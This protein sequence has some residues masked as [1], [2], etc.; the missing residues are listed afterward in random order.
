MALNAR[1]GPM[2]II[3]A[4]GMA[5]GGRVLHHL[6]HRLGDKRNTIILVGYQA[7]GTR[8]R[9]LLEGAESVKMLGPLCP[10][11]RRDR[12]RAGVFGACRS[13]RIIEW[14]RGARS[15]PRSRLHHPWRSARIRSVARR[16]HAAAKMECGG[17]ASSRTGSD[18][19][20]DVSGQ[21]SMSRYAAR[22][23]HRDSRAD[24]ARRTSR[25]QSARSRR[26]SSRIDASGKRHEI[27]GVLN[28]CRDELV[29]LRRNRP[30]GAGVRGPRAARGRRGQCDARGRSAQRRSGARQA[31]RQRASNAPTSTRSS[32]TS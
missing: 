31:G 9:S 11:A 32:P 19:L 1:G 17:A 22:A 8:G 10:G 20:A 13:Q 30:V 16:D 28:F 26:M 15:P 3:S 7:A 24:R 6:A 21:A 27:I 29:A 5:T 12:Q 25:F 2:V 14:L 23:R 18:R 4:S